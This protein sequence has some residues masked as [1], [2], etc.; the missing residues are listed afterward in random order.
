MRIEHQL[1]MH[2]EIIAGAEIVFPEGLMR[3]DH[4]QFDEI[5]R[6]SWMGMLMA[7]R[8]TNPRTT[9]LDE[10]MSFSA[11]VC[12]PS[13][14]ARSRSVVQTAPAFFHVLFNRRVLC[15]VVV[16]KAFGLAARDAQVFAEAKALWP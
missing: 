14:F 6:R 12:A 10:L 2:L 1:V 8:S 13:Q 16:D 3:R 5:R 11:S 9:A 15:K 7:F 4:G